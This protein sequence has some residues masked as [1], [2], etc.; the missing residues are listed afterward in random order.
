[1]PRAFFYNPVLCGGQAVPAG[2]ARSGRAQ[3]QAGRAGRRHRH[4]ICPGDARSGVVILSLRLHQV[5]MSEEAK[6]ISN[7]NDG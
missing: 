5:A 7:T 6:R 1:V 4:S 3:R 2:G